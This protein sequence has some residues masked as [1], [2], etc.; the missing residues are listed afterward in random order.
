MVIIHPDLLIEGRRLRRQEGRRTV[1]FFSH[2]IGAIT[3]DPGR[4]G[5][6]LEYKR[7]ILG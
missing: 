5:A 2:F 6:H 4:Q 7:E 3:A 1:F